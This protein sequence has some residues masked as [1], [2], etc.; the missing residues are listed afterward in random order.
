L[1]KASDLVDLQCDLARHPDLEEVRSVDGMKRLT[2]DSTWHSPFGI[3]SF[4]QP[5]AEDLDC[6]RVRVIDVLWPSSR[7]TRLRFH[8]LAPEL[9]VHPSIRRYRGREMLARLFAFARPS[10]QLAEPRGMRP[11]V[12]HCHFSLGRLYRRT[13]QP[14]EAYEHLATA[15]TMF[16]AMGLTYYLEQAE[17]ERAKVSG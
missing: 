10:R 11:L 9:H 1:I 15:A 13:G 7:S 6:E 2:P 5:G 16:S 14:Q 12:A 4:R 3:S 8:L 17:V